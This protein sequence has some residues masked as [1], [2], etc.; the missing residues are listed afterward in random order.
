MRSVPPQNPE[1]FTGIGHKDTARIFI[2]QLLVKLHRLLLVIQ[3]LFVEHTRLHHRLIGQDPVGVFPYKLTE[4]AV[5]RSVIALLSE[6]FRTFIEH[7]L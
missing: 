5:G 6:Y 3:L 1:I 7:L 4:Q 2:K